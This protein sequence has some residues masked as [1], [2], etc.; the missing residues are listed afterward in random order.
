M[1]FIFR[2]VNRLGKMLSGG[3][4]EDDMRLIID[5][6]Y[7]VSV[8][9]SVSLSVTTCYTQPLSWILSINSKPE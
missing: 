4:K 7:I 8:S 9:L 6:P 2:L 5:W 3:I 1:I